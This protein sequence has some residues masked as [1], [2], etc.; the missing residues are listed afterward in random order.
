MSRTSKPPGRRTRRLEG[1]TPAP[2]P[3]RVC[4]PPAT[5]RGAARGGARPLRPARLAARVPPPGQRK[6]GEPPAESPRAPRSPGEHAGRPDV[7]SARRLTPPVAD[8]TPDPED[9]TPG[10]GCD[11]RA[12]SSR[13]PGKAPPGGRAACRRST[14]VA[15]PSERRAHGLP[16]RRSSRRRVR[17]HG[18][19]RRGRAP[20][21][22]SSGATRRR[23]TGS[24]GTTATRRATRRPRA[25][26]TPRASRPAQR[27]DEGLRVARSPA[28]DAPSAQH[29]AESLGVGCVEAGPAAS[30]PGLRAAVRR[31][32]ATRRG[33]APSGARDRLRGQCP[34][35]VHRAAGNARPGTLASR[36]LRCPCTSTAVRMARAS[37]SSSA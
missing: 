36:R 21:S 18:N 9:A 8:V 35:G 11:S 22:R 2:L 29:G 24:S 14:L 10:P 4:A 25:R 19:G 31:P 26:C 12:L 5:D 7:G 23:G 17:V 33:N 37:R 6:R 32:R 1:S 28:N 3:L 20:C 30:T 34:N 13:Q 15:Q 16:G 27:A